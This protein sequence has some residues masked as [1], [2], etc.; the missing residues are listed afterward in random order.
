MQTNIYGFYGSRWVLVLSVLMK[1]RE[2]DE[3]TF[4]TQSRDILCSI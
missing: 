2:I 1:T 3:S 4:K